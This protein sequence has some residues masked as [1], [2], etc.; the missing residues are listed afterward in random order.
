VRE[1][2]SLGGEIPKS[3]GIVL[4]LEARQKP[5]LHGKAAS[6]FSTQR[7]CG[8]TEAKEMKTMEHCDQCETPDICRSYTGC[9]K[10]PAKEKADD[11]LPLTTC[12]PSYYAD[13]IRQLEGQLATCMATN[14]DLNIRRH[15]AE[16][17]RD[18]LLEAAREVLLF[19][20]NPAT[21]KLRKVI[22]SLE[23]VQGDG[24]PTQ[25]SNEAKR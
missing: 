7:Q 13:R 6:S 22:L 4:L 12:S 1:T 5:P 16:C 15:L 20:S 21:P 8:G 23:N 18:E 10:P 14:V 19:P 9:K 3:A 24:S 11:R 17:E 25:D 2:R